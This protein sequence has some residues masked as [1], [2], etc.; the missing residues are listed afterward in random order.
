MPS[1]TAD[2]LINKEIFAGDKTVKGYNSGGRQ[3]KTFSPGESI[4]IVYSYLNLSSLKVPVLMFYEDVTNFKNP[5]YVKIS[6]GPFQASAEIKKTI[7]QEQTAEQ[8]EQL[9]DKGPFAFYI[10]KYGPYVLATIL[11]LAIIKKKL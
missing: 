9:K 7:K 11:I 2:K 6:D 10:E 4:G 1:L 5:Y 8:Q 3:I